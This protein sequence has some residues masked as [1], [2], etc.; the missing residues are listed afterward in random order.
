M[1]KKH[2]MIMVPFSWERRYNKGVTKTLNVYQIEYTDKTC[3]KR[4]RISGF[5][6]KAEAELKLVEL[7]SK[8]NER[9]L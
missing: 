7:K 1:Q 9:M 5:K 3:N 2:V 4:I 8:N 6:T